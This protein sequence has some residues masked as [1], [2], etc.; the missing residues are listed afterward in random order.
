VTTAAKSRGRELYGIALEALGAPHE[1]RW[2][3]EEASGYP[4]PQALDAP[5]S[6]RSA[7]RISEMVARRAGGEPLQYV[8]GRWAFR[9]LD[10]M[11][12][13]RVLIPRPETEQVV[14]AAL[15][16]LDRARARALGDRALGD[17]ALG[18]RA[19]G[20]PRSRL[21]LADLGTGSGA[22][23]LAVAAE[24]KAV[25]VWATD[26]SPGA[27]DVA[28]AN[29]AGMG[30]FAATRVRFALG[31]WW[32]ALPLELRGRID[33]VVS[34]PPYITTG[35]MQ[36]LEPQVR[37]WEPAVAL[38]AGPTG[39]DCIEEILAGAPAWLR[40]GGAVVLEVAP[41]RVEAASRIAGS[42]GFED[43]SVLDDLAGR[44]RILVA[45][46]AWREAET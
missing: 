35:E 30:G 9:G 25:S 42:C 36:D 37:D 1:A 23:A 8:L 14:D 20:D 19:L 13:G 41:A 2:I 40:P 15:A 3:L 16:E 43:V 6:E 27:I 29:L 10:L 38:D 33:V 18:D 17:R 21:V 24:R 34:N 11:V 45:T 28:S 5:L 44:Q 7:G 12:D 31:S 32:L 4:W 46:L 39:L 26:V 22:I